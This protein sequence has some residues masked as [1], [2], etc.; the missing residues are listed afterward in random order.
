[1]RKTIG[2][3]A[4]FNTNYNGDPMALP[5][6]DTSRLDNTLAVIRTLRDHT[7]GTHR[8]GGNQRH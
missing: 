7:G 5:S 6:T 4:F 3:T 2:M 8:P 1:M